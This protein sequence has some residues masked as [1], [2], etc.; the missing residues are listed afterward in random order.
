MIVHFSVF[1]SRNFKRKQ[2]EEQTGFFKIH[3]DFRTKEKNNA[4]IN[5]FLS[6]HLLA[7]EY[8]F[9]KLN[10]LFLFISRRKKSGRN[11]SCSSNGS[12]DFQIFQKQ[13]KKT[14]RFV[15]FRQSVN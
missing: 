4:V 8:L 10:I 11:W 6:I 1:F 5:R 13:A 2:E 7:S 3:L 15:R 9:F 14:R 12:D